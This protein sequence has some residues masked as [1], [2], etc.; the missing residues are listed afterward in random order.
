MRVH[1]LGFTWL[2]QGLSFVSNICPKVCLATLSGAR[3]F[4]DTSIG[5]A[6]HVTLFRLMVGIVK[7][8]VVSFK[9]SFFMRSVLIT[10]R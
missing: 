10:V 8:L 1:P 9:L 3:A 7:T 5:Q 6:R 2:K 4:E